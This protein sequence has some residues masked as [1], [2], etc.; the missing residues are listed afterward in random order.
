MGVYIYKTH[1]TVFS[2]S[3]HFTVYKLLLN[4]KK[5]RIKKRLFSFTRENNNS[6]F[7]NSVDGLGLFNLPLS[8]FSNYEMD[9]QSQ[10]YVHLW[11][12]NK[13]K[14]TKPLRS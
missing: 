12:E 1:G 2:R 10:C 14:L 3:E 6:W 9:G 8:L 7:A 4:F 5:I 11:S 13:V